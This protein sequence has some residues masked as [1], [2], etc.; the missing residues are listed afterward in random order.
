MRGEWPG[1][2]RLV[3]CA[4]R[5]LAYS[6][7]MVDGRATLCRQLCQEKQIVYLWTLH[8]WRSTQSRMMSRAICPRKP[9]IAHYTV[10]VKSENYGTWL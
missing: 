9:V 3:S 5:G 10:S 1:V 2:A 6:Q 4:S 8:V 7:L